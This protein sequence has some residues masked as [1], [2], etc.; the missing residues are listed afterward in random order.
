MSGR[1]S[2]L[3]RLP[4]ELLDELNRWAKDDLRSLNGQ[5]EYI[6]REALRKRR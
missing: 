4:E 3:L 1:K 6:L 2:Y 5:I